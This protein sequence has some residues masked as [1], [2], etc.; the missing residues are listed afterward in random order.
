[1]PQYFQTQGEEGGRWEGG[2]GGKQVHVHIF[3]HNQLQKDRGDL[4]DDI[5]LS[6]HASSVG[7]EG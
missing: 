7:G 2:R 3:A 6:Q 5:S 1:M 4:K